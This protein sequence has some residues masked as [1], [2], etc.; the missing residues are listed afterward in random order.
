[1]TCVIVPDDPLADVA[2]RWR[3]MWDV[4][5]GQ[6]GAAGFE[7]G[8]AEAPVAWR[9]K[10]F[11]L[12]DYYLVMAPAEP[13]GLSGRFPMIKLVVCKIDC[14]SLRSFDL[15]EDLVGI[16]GPGERDRVLVP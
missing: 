9:D 4:P 3:A 15:A 11:D 14:F 1:M 8:A 6:E 12:P 13:D 16:L 10:R 2:A 5:G 7:A